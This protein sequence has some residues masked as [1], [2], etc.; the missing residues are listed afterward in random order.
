MTT[1]FLIAIATTLAFLA[2][3]ASSLRG[4]ARDERRRDAPRVSFGRRAA[5]RLFS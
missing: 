1:V 4:F 3:A 5:D 2:A